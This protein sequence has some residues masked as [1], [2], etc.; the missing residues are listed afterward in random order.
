MRSLFVVPALLLTGALVMAQPGTPPADPNAGLDQVLAGWEKAL[1]SIKSLEAK[2]QRTTLDKVFQTKEVFSGTAKYLKGA[3]P[4]QTSRASLELFKE[5]P[6][7]LNR[8]VFEKYI[9]SGTF[10]YEYSPANKVIRIHDL[11]QPKQGQISDDNFLSFLFGMKAHEAKQ[12]YQLTMTA[13]DQHYHYIHIKPNLQQD[14]ADFTVARL[15][16]LRANFLP[17]QVWFHQPNGNEVTWNF[18]VDPNVDIP[19]SVFAQPQLDPGWKF[20]RMPAQAQP[21]IRSTGP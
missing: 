11:P 15:V 8:N 1:T 5:T 18:K 9:C 3:G 16:L 13:P 19:A 17:A 7:G 2:C 6:Q 21:K 10:L 12:R 14:K 4:G 20:E